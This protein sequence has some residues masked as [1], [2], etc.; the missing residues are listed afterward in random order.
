MIFEGAED[1]SSK[2]G[3]GREKLSLLVKLEHGK[4]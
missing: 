3:Y 1:L 4:Q 2:G